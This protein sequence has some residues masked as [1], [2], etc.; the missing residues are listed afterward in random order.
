[1]LT[2]PFHKD[3]V[4]KPLDTVDFETAGA[5]MTDYS[6]G[7][8]FTVGREPKALEIKKSHQDEAIEVYKFLNLLQK[9]QQRLVMHRE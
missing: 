4:L 2:P 7:L 3:G 8:R 9:H 1:M 5:G 6:C